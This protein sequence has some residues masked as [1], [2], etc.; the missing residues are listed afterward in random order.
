MASV[1]SSKGTDMFSA[2]HVIDG[3]IGVI[4]SLFAAIAGVLW[5]KVEGLQKELAEHKASTPK[6]YVSKEDY[7][8]DMDYVKNALDDILRALGGKADRQH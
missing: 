5:G 8:A 4:M 2:Q 6:E 3:L 1:S 7:R